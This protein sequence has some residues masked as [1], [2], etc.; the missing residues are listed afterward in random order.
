MNYNSNA[1]KSFFSLF[2]FIFLLSVFLP[3]N[4]AQ[5]AVP[6]IINFQGRLYDDT[7]TLLGGAGT[8]FCF[9]F[10][11]WDVS[12]GGTA[13]P[14]QIWPGSFA[15]PSAMTLVVRNGVFDA[16]IG[17]GVDTLDFNFQSDD[18]VYVDVQVAEKVGA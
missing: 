9:K 15:D 14:N 2:F 18:E 7:E 12:T 13:D 17:S 4:F 10:G 11:I 8:D 3:T 5:A 6:L 16:Y 1:I